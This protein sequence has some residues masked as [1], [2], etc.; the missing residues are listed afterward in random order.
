MQ[1]IAF[2]LLFMVTASIMGSS[3]ARKADALGQVRLDEET[4]TEATLEVDNSSSFVDDGVDPED[5]VMFKS[6]TNVNQR[7]GVEIDSDDGEA[8]GTRPDLIMQRNVTDLEFVGKLSSPV[9]LQAV[10]VRG[11]DPEK[12][13]EFLA[14]VKAHAELK[15]GQ[16]LENFARGILLKDENIESLESNDESVEIAYKMP[17]KFLGV[18]PASIRANTS[19]STRSKSTNTTDTQAR[20]KVKF[21]WYRFLF[22]LDGNVKADSLASVIEEALLAIGDASADDPRYV[23]RVM[24]TTSTALKIKHDTV[25]NSI[26]NVR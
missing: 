10:E 21:P 7:L 6:G 2:I 18:V 15:S 4:N 17:A 22:R 5:K 9:A 25:K 12:K 13:K 23:G 3:L 24:F 16:D 1:T 19:V 11:W 14:T 8:T 26:N 20:V